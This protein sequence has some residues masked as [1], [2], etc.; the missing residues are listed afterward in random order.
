L[1][2]TTIIMGTSVIFAATPLIFELACEISYPTGEGTANGVLTLLNNLFGG[3][4]L[5]IMLDPSIGRL[6]THERF[7]RMLFIRTKYTKMRILGVIAFIKLQNN[8]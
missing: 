8:I 2:C 4:F 6:S 5:L 1:F 7:K 3:I